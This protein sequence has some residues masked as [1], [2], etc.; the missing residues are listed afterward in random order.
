[1]ET[2][3]Y[4][5]DLVAAERFYAGV[6]GLK[7]IARDEGRDVFFRCGDGVF[8][9]F[10]PAATIIGAER[11]A[12]GHPGA[13]HVAFVLEEHEVDAWQATLASHGVPIELDLIPP[14]GGRSVYFRDP[15]GNSVELA[16]RR[17]WSSH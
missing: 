3:L 4:A 9:V 6:L 15:A 2:C 12:H 16:T 5:D 10:N 7:V 8:L 11:P 1:M 14:T 17:V 13:G